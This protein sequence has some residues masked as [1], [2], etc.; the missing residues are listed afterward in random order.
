MERIEWT[1][2]A[3][4]GTTKD[5]ADSILEEGYRESTGTGHWFGKGVYF[6]VRDPVFAMEFVKRQITR[7]KQ[8]SEC[9]V[10]GWG[11]LRST[12]NMVTIFDLTLMK[13]KELLRGFATR[14][15]S[16]IPES[17]RTVK[18]NQIT[19]EL[20][21]LVLETFRVEHLDESKNPKYSGVLGISAA[22]NGRVPKGIYPPDGPLYSTSTSSSWIDFHDHLQLCMWDKKY[23]TS[24][25]I[26]I[27]GE[28]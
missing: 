19:R 23:I 11:V 14:L 17:V 4:H 22:R 16:E 3:F 12:V 24:T 20:D 7:K 8:Q 2:E 5:S 25:A 15:L 28:L 9:G 26:F 1:L 10:I 13:N 18:Q 6:S 27:T 21:A